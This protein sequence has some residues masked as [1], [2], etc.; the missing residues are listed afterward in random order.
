MIY[1]ISK[2]NMSYN[3]IEYKNTETMDNK[4]TDIL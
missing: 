4:N 3:N 1:T 2:L